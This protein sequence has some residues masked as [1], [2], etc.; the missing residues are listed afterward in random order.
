MEN[1]EKELKIKIN[2]LAEHYNDLPETDLEG[3][4]MAMEIEYGKSYQKLY[5]MVAEK[6]IEN[7]LDYF[8][9]IIMT[10]PCYNAEYVRENEIA[11]IKELE[12]KFNCKI[13]YFSYDVE[14]LNK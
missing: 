3:I 8:N 10:N 13:N 11:R 14:F 5:N 6:V 2:E 9:N 1:R 4:L 7:S 12:A